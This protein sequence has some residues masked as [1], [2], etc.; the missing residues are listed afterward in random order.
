MFENAPFL[1][2]SSTPLMNSRV[3]E[4]SFVDSS[5]PPVNSRVEEVS[6]VDSNSNL[7]WKSRFMELSLCST[8]FLC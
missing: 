8:V 4:V 6:F 3:E 7:S 1:V 2:D 5:S